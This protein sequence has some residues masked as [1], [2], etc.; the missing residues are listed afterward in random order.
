MRTNKRALNVLILL[1]LGL[2]FVG[3]LIFGHIFYTMLFNQDS[4]LILRANELNEY[5][6]EFILINIALFITF[7]TFIYMIKGF[8]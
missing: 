3:Y 8:E 5:W 2:G 1:S 7:I 4:N 6:F